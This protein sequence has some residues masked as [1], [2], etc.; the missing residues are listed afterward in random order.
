MKKCPF[1][2]EEV[3]D[4]AVKCKHCHSSLTDSETSVKASM[5][6]P[7]EQK[8][9][10]GH[11]VPHNALARFSFV[12][13]LGWCIFFFTVF[14]I[15]FEMP[16]IGATLIIGGAWV[17]PLKKQT[18]TKV[19]DR[20]RNWKRHLLRLGIS[21]FFI[22][23]TVLL[24]AADVANQTTPE[25]DAASYQA[26]I[27]ASARLEQLR[28][29]ST[30]STGLL[31][32]IE[33]SSFIGTESVKAIVETYSE[34]NAKKEIDVTV[35]LEDSAVESALLVD[36]SFIMLAVNRATDLEPDIDRITIKFI[37]TLVNAYGEKEDVQVMF[38]QY[39][40]ATWERIDWQNSLI[41]NIPATADV[42]TEHDAIR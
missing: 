40:R 9:A 19:M 36:A 32:D 30:S 26:L 34:A 41:D 23:M 21:L 7:G 12:R 4:Q 31:H 25:E 28:V 37:Q 2:A 15:W 11:T 42:F 13:T 29:S 10:Q 27:E 24:I 14:Y 5:S 38:I 22:L 1:C 20:L 33:S 16:L 35:Q 6:Q 39:N 17:M 18:D 8:P 3:Q